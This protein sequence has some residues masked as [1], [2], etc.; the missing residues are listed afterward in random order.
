[1]FRHAPEESRRIYAFPRFYILRRTSKYLLNTK[2][3]AILAQVLLNPLKLSQLLLAF[4]INML[5]PTPNPP[6][7]RPFLATSTM[8]TL[9]S[10][11]LHYI[12]ITRGY[13]VRQRRCSY[14]ED[15][16]CH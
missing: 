6:P 12:W 4:I 11:T 10:A 13:L 3:M 5:F 9:S 15:Q 7:S 14:E 8:P 16:L 1:M 2:T